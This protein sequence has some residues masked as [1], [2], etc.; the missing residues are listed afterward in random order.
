MTL[1]CTQTLVTYLGDNH[2]RDFAIPFPVLDQ[3]HLFPG[4]ADS[5]GTPQAF[6][7]GKDYAY[8]T[9][10]NAYGE[11]HPEAIMLTTPL[12]AGWTLTLRRQVP[13]TQ[14]NF[15][16][17]QGPN[18]PRVMEK[19]LD[20]LTMICQETSQR[21]DSGLPELQDA[22]ADLDN[23]LAAS[24]TFLNR[25]VD[26]LA[27]FCQETGQQLDGMTQQ[28]GSALPAL[29]T[30][31]A[32]LDSRLTADE[33]AWNNS[34]NAAKTTLN[35]RLDTLA[36]SQQE[37]TERLDTGLADLQNQSAGL[38]SSLAAAEAALNGR[39]DS[40]AADQQETA[41]EL[42]AAQTAWQNN[43]T[44]LTSS[45][46]A[47]EAALSG[48]L[49]SLAANQQ[50]TAQELAAV[51]QLLDADL[52]ELRSGLTHLENQLRAVETLVNGKASQTALAELA[53]RLEE[54]MPAAPDDGKIHGGLGKT[55]APF[56]PSQGENPFAREGDYL[57]TVASSGYAA[58]DLWHAGT[59][60]IS[61]AAAARPG[62]A[63]ALF[64]IDP[65]GYCVVK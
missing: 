59:S 43:F 31:L 41:Q 62:D 27:T 44:G 36:A 16:H 24:E 42:A 52:P 40:L 35:S 19:S 9:G 26:D 10:R 61:L 6:A 5:A 34:L 13:L 47:A 30:G 46:A 37:T 25:R 57:V 15:F 33:F 45:L 21:L 50:G 32:H 12:P 38:T 4:V 1:E 53:L 22:C 49:D 56:T 7:E 11:F 54:T 8:R 20:K 60:Y 51:S 48:R 39:L 29:Q 14:E 2:T 64:H 18:S 55:W 63:D 17:N 58:N 65:E 23:R 3:T 28:L